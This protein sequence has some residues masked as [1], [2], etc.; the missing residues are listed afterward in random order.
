MLQWLIDRLTGRKAKEKDGRK[1]ERV[2]EGE[3]G[4]RFENAVSKT[5]ELWVRID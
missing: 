5:E 1:V 3:V 4:I 2:S